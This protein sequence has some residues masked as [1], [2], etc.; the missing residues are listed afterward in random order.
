MAREVD[1]PIANLLPTQAIVHGRIIDELK[2]EVAAGL[3]LDPLLLVPY[4]DVPLGI[5]AD[6]HH[7]TYTQHSLGLTVVRATLAET[8]A[9]IQA[10]TSGPLKRYNSVEHVVGVYERRWLPYIRTRGVETIDDFLNKRPDRSRLRYA[11]RV[12]V[13]ELTGN[14]S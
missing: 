10:I 13:D 2:E 3:A 6:G 9:D 4:G 1:F 5:I 12:F 8:D 11:F 7:R 14:H